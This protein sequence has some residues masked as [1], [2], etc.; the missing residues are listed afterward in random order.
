[1]LIEDL[2]VSEILKADLAFE[3]EEYDGYIET[4]KSGSEDVKFVH[5]MLG[6]NY[7]GEGCMQWDRVK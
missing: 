2:S 1:M 7:N 4:I 5:E 6:N 3:R